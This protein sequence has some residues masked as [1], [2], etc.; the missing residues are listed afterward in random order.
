MWSGSISKAK[1]RRYR[2]LSNFFLPLAR[3]PRPSRI[4]A[5]MPQTNLKTLATTVN[6]VRQLAGSGRIAGADLR[7]QGGG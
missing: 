7:F 6:Y 3:V 2:N 5:L 4:V 1:L